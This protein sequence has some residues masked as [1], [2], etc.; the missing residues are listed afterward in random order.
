MPIRRMRKYVRTAK[1][2]AWI[3]SHTETAIS[4]S[5]IAAFTDGGIS[6]SASAARVA[7]LQNSVF[8]GMVHLHHETEV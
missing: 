7:A 1:V 5:A 3:R 8:D 4:T 2:L 6:V